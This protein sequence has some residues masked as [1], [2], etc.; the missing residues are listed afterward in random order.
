[1]PYLIKQLRV[2]PPPSEGGE[3]LPG[4]QGRRCP[5]VSVVGPVTTPS[6]T[7]Y[8]KKQFITK[9]KRRKKEGEKTTTTKSET[10]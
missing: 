10:I 8:K 7:R 2:S 3:T 1:M 9:T 6:V 4:L 5:A